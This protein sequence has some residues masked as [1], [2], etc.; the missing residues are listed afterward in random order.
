MNGKTK[1]ITM[2]KD[3]FN[4]WE[5]LLADL[6]E[7]QI[8]ATHLDFKMSIKDVLAH[9]QQRSVAKME[10]AQ[11]NKEPEYPDWPGELNPES[12][13]VDL[14]N[15]WIYEKYH[16]LPW[17]DVHQEWKERYLRF[18]E[19]AETIP[20]KDLLDTERYP[21][22]GGYALSAVLIGSYEHHQEHL[23][24]LPARLAR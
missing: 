2:L 21:W 10:A 8:I 5:E 17:S 1:L 12:E 11:H 22:L 9:L 15:A 4:R 14:I 24:D 19:L 6:N 7:E 20:E 23:E 3:E 13:D 18:L 16:G